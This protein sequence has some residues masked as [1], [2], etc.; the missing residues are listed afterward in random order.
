MYDV[1]LFVQGIHGTAKLDPATGVV[2]VDPGRGFPPMR[3]DLRGMLHYHGL[4][5]LPRVHTDGDTSLPL[6]TRNGTYTG[7]LRG[8]DGTYT[9]NTPAL[10]GT[11]HASPGDAAVARAKHLKREKREREIANSGDKDDV[12]FVLERTRE[13]RDAEG[14]ANAIALE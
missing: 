2:H 5:D 13:E 7:V 14:R 9:C 4:L 3:L 12:E 11:V 8:P 1:T 6:A 10:R